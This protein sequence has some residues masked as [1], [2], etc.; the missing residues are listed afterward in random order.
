[1]IDK[2]SKEGVCRTLKI[3]KKYFDRKI[4]KYELILKTSALI[5]V[6][7]QIHKKILK[8]DGILDA[9][10]KSTSAIE[11][12]G[13]E[14]LEIINHSV[15]GIIKNSNKQS[16]DFQKMYWEVVFGFN[17]YLVTQNDHYVEE[18]FKLKIVDISRQLTNKVERLK[19]IIE[20]YNDN[21]N[22]IE[23]VFLEMIMFSSIA[24]LTYEKTML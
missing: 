3:S 21:Q 1:M 8:I 13:Y 18:I 9:G 22:L 6:S 20:R 19:K 4:A 14:F 16:V 12:F 7:D 24:Y 5:Y 2:L 15:I 10:L 17:C 11:D 23:G